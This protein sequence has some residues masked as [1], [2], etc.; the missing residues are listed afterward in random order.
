MN[1]LDLIILVAYI[2]TVV[3]VLRQAIAS[4]NKMTELEFSDEGLQGAL[5]RYE[6][7]E[8]LD[9][10]FKLPDPYPMGEQPKAMLL[11][12]TNHLE[13]AVFI[14]WDRS[15]FTDTK[16]RSRRVIRLVP[17]KG[18]EAISA[19]V[20]S[21]I[22]PGKTIQE[23]I[24]AEDSLEYDGDALKAQKPIVDI[25]KPEKFAEGDTVGFSLWLVIHMQE[26][27][28]L[29]DWTCI[30]PCDFIVRRCLWTDSLPF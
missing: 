21:P 10:S 9:I 19:Q 14:D 25:E 7:S 24:T 17:Y 29:D 13:R 30:L 4:V 15:T 26:T 20:Y 22:P 2:I 8:Q 27:E 5:K 12:V 23:A 18:S 16:G 1:Q 28:D 11:I 6:L 3:L